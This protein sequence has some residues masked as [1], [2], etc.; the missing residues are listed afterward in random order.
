M[1]LSGITR[2]QLKRLSPW[3]SAMLE[4]KLSFEMLS[5]NVTSVDGTRTEARGTFAQPVRCE[6]NAS[7]DNI[8][9]CL[10]PENRHGRK[11]RHLPVGAGRPNEKK[12]SYVQP[13]G[14]RGEQVLAPDLVRKSTKG[15]YKQGLLI[16]LGTVI[17]FEKPWSILIDSGASVNYVRRQFLEGNQQY[18]DALKP[19]EG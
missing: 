18:A 7:T 9:P 5:R 14:G 6:I 8:V 3:I 10:K 13:L 17:Y 19:H 1:A 11:K 16:A 15:E 4:K 2:S 12:L